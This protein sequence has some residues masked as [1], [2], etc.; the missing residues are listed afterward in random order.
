MPSFIDQK[1]EANT[2]THVPRVDD[3]TQRVEGCDV[4][5]SIQTGD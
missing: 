3:P 4:T 1:T 5:E 2:E